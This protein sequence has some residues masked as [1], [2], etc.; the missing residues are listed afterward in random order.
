[1][2]ECIGG[3]IPEDFQKKTSTLSFFED[4]MSNYLNQ[5]FEKAVNAFEQVVAFYPYDLTS[6]FFL[7]LAIGF[8]FTGVPS[9]WFVV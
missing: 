7:E 5:S 2:Y 1:M 8:T 4:G 9:N 6:K 3:G